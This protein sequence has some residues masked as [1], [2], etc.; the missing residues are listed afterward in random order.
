MSEL[1]CRSSMICQRIL[2]PVGYISLANV[3][4]LSCGH[5]MLSKVSKLLL[6][7]LSIIPNIE[8][9]GGI[10]IHTEF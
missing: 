6:C 10:L 4:I 8:L 9:F 3:I 5:Q 2:S 7:V 1:L